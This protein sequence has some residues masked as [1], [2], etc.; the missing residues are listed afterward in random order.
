[1]MRES[2][3]EPWWNCILFFSCC[4]TSILYVFYIFFSSVWG[5]Y[6]YT[7]PYLQWYGLKK[8]QEHGNRTSAVL[9]SPCTQILIDNI[10]ILSCILPCWP[11]GSLATA[12][13]MPIGLSKLL[14]CVPSSF[15]FTLGT[16]TPNFCTE[17]NQ[18]VD[19]C[20]SVKLSYLPPWDTILGK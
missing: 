13:Q 4:M 5:K 14:T 18:M 1:M 12:Q 7:N 15:Y 11:R 16:L 19:Q 3:C 6:S 9:D 2:W 17:M 8:L 10:I 20:L